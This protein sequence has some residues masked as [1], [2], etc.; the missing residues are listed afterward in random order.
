MAETFQ[1]RDLFNPTAVTAMGERFQKID[2]N[3]DLT[4]FTT[5]INPKL[6]ALTYS[7]RLQLITE[8]QEKY[9]PNHFPTAAKLIVDSLIPAYESDEFED[10]N[11][12]FIVATKAAYIAQ[13]GL[14]HFDISMNA[15]YE[16]TKRMSSE[17]GVR[18]FFIKYPEKTLAVF[19]KWA[20][21]DNPHVRRLVSEG[22]RPYLPWGKK[23]A[24]FEKDPTPTLALLEYLKNDPSE[25][26]RRSVANHLND[27]SK[28]HADLVVKTLKRWQSATSN[29]NELRMIKHALRTLLKKGHTG[30][31]D[32]LGYKKGAKVKVNQLVADKKVNV[33]DYL[34]FSF[35]VQSTGKTTQ[36]LMIDYV[37][38]YQKAHGELAPKVFKMTTKDVVAG[39]SLSLK[40]RQSFKVITTRKFHLGKHQLAIQING[41]ELAKID[42]ELLNAQS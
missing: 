19:K 27:H 3:F 32:I 29:K 36:P 4:G 39:A 41:E 23:L 26:V 20:T 6:S 21:D 7:E 40:K 12:R 28:K 42:F 37:I 25:Y 14:E 2:A 33:G 1:V 30:A 38:Y 8:G 34:N 11:N 15:L 9:L 17:W 18:P 24:Q 5:F 22:S 13:N 10:A 35:E 16:I 31:L